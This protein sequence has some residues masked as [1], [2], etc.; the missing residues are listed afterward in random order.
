MS[1]DH[2]GQEGMTYPVSIIEDCRIL[3]GR[4]PSAVCKRGVSAGRCPRGVHGGRL[5]LLHRQ[6]RRVLGLR[7]PGEGALRHVPA[8]DSSRLAARPRRRLRCA[9]LEH[10]CLPCRQLCGACLASAS[11]L[12]TASVAARSIWACLVLTLDPAHLCS[13]PCTLACRA[14]YCSR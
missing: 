12:S 13:Q 9:L 4:R 10:H 11:P 7:Q 8:C 2:R 3:P 5:V 1:P 6:H 14:T